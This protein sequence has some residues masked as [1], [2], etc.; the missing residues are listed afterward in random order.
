MA[1]GSIRLAACGLSGTFLAPEAPSRS[2]KRLQRLLTRGGAKSM[3]GHQCGNQTTMLGDDRRLSFL[4]GFQE[5]RELIA[6]LLG[7]FA[8]QF[9]SF[10]TSNQ[11]VQGRT[12]WGQ[13]RRL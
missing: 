10:S 13:E 12:V 5:V 1:I 9:S 3:D 4:G 11:P 2:R 6:R 8:Q 7:A